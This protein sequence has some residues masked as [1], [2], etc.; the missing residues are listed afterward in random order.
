MLERL[1]ID[2]E[3]CMLVQAGGAKAKHILVVL[4]YPQ[5]LSLTWSAQSRLS[6]RPLRIA[7]KP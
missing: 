7:L 1:A 2:C 4:D 5:N 6:P 3:A